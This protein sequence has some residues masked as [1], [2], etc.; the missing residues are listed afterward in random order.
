MPMLIKG[1]IMVA[2]NGIDEAVDLYREAL[3]KARVLSSYIACWA[4]YTE[5]WEDMKML[6]W[7]IKWQLYSIA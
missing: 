7:N 6:F 1:W 2:R 4:T 3:E 5:Q